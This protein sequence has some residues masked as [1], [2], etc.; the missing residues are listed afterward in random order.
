[1]WVVLLQERGGNKN[2]SIAAVDGW[3]QLGWLPFLNYTKENPV[4]FQKYNLNNQ[5]D[6]Y[7]DILRLFQ[8]MRDPTSARKR[9]THTNFLQIL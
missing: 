6:T 8:V 3:Y 2:P 9:L 7:E 5:A 4:S 1:M